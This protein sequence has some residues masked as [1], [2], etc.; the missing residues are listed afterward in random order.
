MR[1]FSWV[2]PL[3][4]AFSF[5]HAHS[6]LSTMATVNNTRSKNQ[7]RKKDAFPDKIDIRDW[8]YQPTLSILPD[9]IVN[10]ERVP[11]I[12]DQG[13][14]GACTGFAL[15]AVVNFHLAQ[16]GIPFSRTAK[17]EVSPRMLYELARK[18]DE[19]PGEQ[20]EGSSAR[21]TIKG[22]VA[23]GVCQRSLWKDTMHGVNHFSFDIGNESKKIPGGAYYRIQHKNIRDIHAALF[24]SGIIYATLMVHDGWD[25]PG[26]Q[27]RKKERNTYSCFDHVRKKTWK[28][29]VI[30]RDGRATSG[31]AIALVGYTDQGFIVQNS[32][33]TGWGEKGFALLPYED[34]IMHATDAWVVQIGVPVKAT[35]WEENK[36]ADTTA[37]SYRLA[38]SISMN[39][40]RKHVVDIGNNGKLSDTGSY[41][42]TTE[43]IRNIFTEMN[44]K[45]D[46]WNTLRILLYLHGGL[47]GE[48]EVA[49]R[50]VA[51]KDVMMKNRIYP[52]HIMWETGVWETL[53]SQFDDLFTSD[54][55]RAGAGLIDKL[56]NTVSEV[57][58][59]IFE[60]TTSKI[61]T[62]M[63]DEMKENARLASLPDGG[64]SMLCEI[65]KEMYGKMQLKNRQKVELHIVGHSAGSIFTSYAI[66]KL[67]EIGIPVKT[68]QFMAP[69]ATISLFKEKMLP[70]MKQGKIP[71][72][73]IYNLT[74]NAEK[75]D[76]VGPYR[77]SL[78][79]LVSNAFERSRETPILGMDRFLRAD[80][81]LKAIYG[82][83]GAPYFAS[84][85]SSDTKISQSKTHGGF[86][87]DV[88]TMNSVMKQ[89]LGVNPKPEFTS[90]DLG[91]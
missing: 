22:W 42:T 57:G 85:G 21:G 24:E 87:N 15:A 9:Q 13:E 31:H 43:D 51:F 41:W 89:I 38:S 91:Y 32:W 35:L 81:A 18:Y 63:W 78:L 30:V 26:Y 10:C 6:A 76:T 49:Q 65:A 3:G 50:V 1:L 60:L 23:H 83:S 75:D 56:K 55:E 12:L 62:M 84:S 14:E 69:A 72:P 88:F 25:D 36:A 11:L 77:K 52:V 74:D 82:K 66:E 37:G 54:D 40:I 19:W 8:Y 53:K 2:D 27:K 4:E 48:K 5:E 64:M 68:I 80:G 58:D 79:Y 17:N 67:L 73:F 86:D 90:R 45:I 7:R 16:K 46:E 39:E 34:W 71:T 29:P 28:L 59:K 61:G 20:Y 44:S 70:L 47:N 33:G